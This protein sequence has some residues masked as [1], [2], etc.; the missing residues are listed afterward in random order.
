MTNSAEPSAFFIKAQGVSAL[1]SFFATR[2]RN[3]C[4]LSSRVDPCLLYFQPAWTQAA[5]T[6]SEK[7]HDSTSL[8]PSLNPPANKWTSTSSKSA[9]SLNGACPILS[10]RVVRRQDLRRRTMVSRS[11]WCLKYLPTIFCVSRAICRQPRIEAVRPHPRLEGDADP[12]SSARP[13]P[14]RAG[15]GSAHRQHLPDHTRENMSTNPTK[16]MYRKSDQPIVAL[17]EGSPPLEVRLERSYFID[18]FVEF[19][20]RSRPTFLRPAAG[21]RRDRVIPRRPRRA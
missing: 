9:W 16:K 7:M 17:S 12:W 19:Q 14:S 6:L 15:T 8:S 18:E 11:A 10:E 5:Y 20:A 21:H 2:S 13:T 4:G 3:H 1:A